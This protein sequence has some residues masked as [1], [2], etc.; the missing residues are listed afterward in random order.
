MDEHTVELGISYPKKALKI[1]INIWIKYRTPHTIRYIYKVDHKY[2][3]VFFKQC[4]YLLL[5]CNF[6]CTVVN[7]IEQRLN[8]TTLISEYLHL[9][10]IHKYV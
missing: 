4:T 8:R 3:K 5:L 2:I 10:H 9:I 7:I 6:F 1:I